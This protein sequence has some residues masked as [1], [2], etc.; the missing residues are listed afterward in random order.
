MLINKRLFVLILASM[1]TGLGASPKAGA[2]GADPE[3]IVLG[4]PANSSIAVHVLATAETEIYC[5]YGEVPGEYSDQTTVVRASVEGLAEISVE[6][7]Q[8]DRAYFYRLNYRS[9]GAS[10]YR[11]GDEHSFRTQRSS[12]STFSF[13]VQGDSHPERT[14]PGRM[15]HPD[16]YVRTMKNIESAQP[17]LYFMLGD[18]FSISGAMYAN[19]LSQQLVDDVYSNQRNYLSLM[20]HSTSLFLV[21]GNHEEARRHLL[22]GKGMYEGAE[23]APIFAG[24]A[25][26]KLYPLPFPNHFYT[27]DNQR[28]PGVGLPRDYYA[29][30]WGDALFIAIDP[31]WHS[32]VAVGGKRNKAFDESIDP[33]TGRKDERIPHYLPEESW[34]ATIGDAQYQWFNRTLEQSDAKY[35]FVFAHHVRGTGRGAVEMVRE[36]E[37]GGYGADG[38]WEFDEMRPDW[39]LPIHQLMVKHGV[40]IFFQGHDHLFAR[41]EIDG[42]VYQEVPNPADATPGEEFCGSCFYEYYKSGIVLPNSGYLNVTVSPEQVRVDYVKSYLPEG[43]VLWDDVKVELDGHKNGELARSYVVR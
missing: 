9:P 15:F 29:F 13:G 1:L 35:K 6:G 32:P 21:N 10:T 26:T 37:W 43:F 18:D 2:Q 27:G 3:N 19:R 28:V 7:L 41:Q 34:A 38:T 4:R 17:D 22:L 31:Y 36:F 40:T 12:G 42:I 5:E 25:R 20:A 16:L 33:E 24:R 23:N 8:P 11:P 14:G 30:T 39:E